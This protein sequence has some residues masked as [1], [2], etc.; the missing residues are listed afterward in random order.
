[1]T[2]GDTVRLPFLMH[3]VSPG[4]ILRLDRATSIGSRDFTLLGGSPTKSYKQRADEITSPRIAPAAVEPI[5]G[6]TDDIPQTSATNEAGQEAG[7]KKK[8]PPAYLDERLFVCRA[9]V[10]GTEAEPMRVKEKTK[11]RQRRVKTVRSKHKYT[12]IKIREFTVKTLGELE[13]VSESG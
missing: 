3:G 10:M 7:G 13:G 1:M 8:G 11:R 5:V 12:V 2:V 4:T 9:V 6:K